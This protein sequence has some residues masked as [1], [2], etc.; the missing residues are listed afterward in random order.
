M[1][2]REDGSQPQISSIITII[3]LV[4][5]VL[6]LPGV[7]W[8]FFGWLHIL[9]PLV[10]FY[11][12]CR[13]GMH[14]GNKLLLTAVG[15]SFATFLALQR[16]D[17][18]FF[19]ISLLPIGYILSNSADRKDSPALS[20]LKGALTLAG[21]WAIIF[22][23]LSVGSEVSFYSQLINTLDEGINE[24]LEYYRVSSDMSG[25]NLVLLEGMLHQMKVLVPI[26]MP[27]ILGSFVLLVTWFTMVIGNRLVLKTCGRSI[28][29]EYKFWSLSDKLIWL[30]I[31]LALFALIP[32]HPARSIGINCL[33][34]LSIVYCFQGL[35]IAIFF[36]DKWNVPIVFR[37]F[38][39]VMIVFQ[40][41]G[42]VLL[43][44]FGIADIWFDFR[45]L[46]KVD[47][48]TIE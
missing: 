2:T 47:E 22:A 9:L 34:L 35:S 1:D 30:F 18:F 4:F 38:F 42:T 27:A 43:L 8:S 7:Q 23:F 48:E 31:F 39:Y 46:H 11:L 12:L 19:S 21:S 6:V 28:W 24:T 3:L 26:I 29:G 45:K 32:V 37:S 44:F 33:I 25:E 14:V 10:S 41:F 17:F 40:S 20:G 15:L 5:L 36:L 13:F 16:V